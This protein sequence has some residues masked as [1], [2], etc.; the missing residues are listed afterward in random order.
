MP[1]YLN[2]CLRQDMQHDIRSCTAFNVFKVD[3]SYHQLND[4]EAPTDD[5]KHG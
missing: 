2:I 1:D 4:F 3:G 5:K